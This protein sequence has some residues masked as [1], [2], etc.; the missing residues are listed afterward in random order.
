MKKFKLFVMSVLVISLAACGNGGKINPTSKKVNG[1][2]GKFFEVVE[3]D[4]KINDN[5]L[6]V[7][8]KRIAEGGPTN[9]SWS[10]HPTFLVELQD[11]D[12]NAISTENTDVVFTKEQ[13][14][15]IFSLGVDETASITF[16]FKK[17]EGTTRFKVSSKWDADSDL[18]SS[19]DSDI[20]G[21]HD[22]HG[23]VENYPITMHL[24]IDGNS[25]KGS[26]YYDKQGA[27]AKLKL[28]GTNEDG[29]LDINET[30]SNGTPTGHFK[31]KFS[32]KTFMGMFITNQGKK[33]PFELSEDGVSGDGTAFNSLNDNEAKTSI[34]VILPSALRGKVEVAYCSDV[35]EGKYGYPEVE[36]GFK[37]LQTVNTSSLASSYGQL[38]IVGV[39]LDEQGRNVKE[40]LPNYEEW[41]S[42]DSDGKEFKEFLESNPGET[43]NLTFSGGKEGDVSEGIKKVAKF[44]LKLTN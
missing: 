29:L 33:M 21:A 10:T 1:P 14:E 6:S 23:A 38:W 4:Y 28:V 16:K 36:I 25:V 11:E 3:R 27:N 37:L 20:N 2:L 31:G 26:Y 8:F 18:P 17:T 9:A 15:S 41:R 34:E 22:M 19:N 40:L 7:E 5:E 24:E 39:G 35:T 44:K 12:G 32:N 42:G 30:D 13:L 43:I